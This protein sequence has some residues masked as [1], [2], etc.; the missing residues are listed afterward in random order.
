MKS[1]SSFS[2]CILCLI[3]VRCICSLDLCLLFLL[4]L[5]SSLY[6]FQIFVCLTFVLLFLSG[7][8][9]KFWK[10]LSDCG[11]FLL[12]SQASWSIQTLKCCSSVSF[13]WQ[14]FIGIGFSVVRN[15]KHPFC[16]L[17]FYINKLLY[18]KFQ[19]SVY[20]HITLS[21]WSLDNFVW[22]WFEVD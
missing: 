17:V 22:I 18:V 9:L 20:L 15:T 2:L 14:G 8:Q 5:P 21:F 16:Q 13:Q 1:N 4:L 7:D 11:F 6:I 3:A 12:Y 10:T 19:C